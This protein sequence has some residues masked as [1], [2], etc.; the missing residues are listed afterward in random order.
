MGGNII[1]NILSDK[2]FD[3]ASIIA[4][5]AYQPALD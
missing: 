3:N 1:I 4:A 5:V 2:E